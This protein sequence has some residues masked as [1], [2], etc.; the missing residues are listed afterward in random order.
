MLTKLKLK[1]KY[2]YTLLNEDLKCLGV[3]IKS[4]SFAPSTSNPPLLHLLLASYPSS[5]FSLNKFENEL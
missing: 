4:K 2:W 3:G 1:K 5:P